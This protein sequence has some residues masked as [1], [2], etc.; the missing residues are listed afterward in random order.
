M[1][2]LRLTPH[3]YWPPKYVKKWDVGLDP[4]GGMQTQIYRM[5]LALSK[6]NVNQKILTIGMKGAQ[7]KIK[8]KDNVELCASNVPIIPIKSKVRGTVGLNFYWGLGVILTDLKILL[9]SAVLKKGKWDIIHSHCS[10][11]AA[12]LLVGII[13]K[14]LLKKPLVYTVHC[15]RLCTYEPM[16]KLDQMINKSIIKL[17]E[18]CLKKSDHILVLTQ[19]TKDLLLTNYKHLNDSKISIIPDIVSFNS[20]CMKVNE[21][22]KDFLYTKYKIPKDKRIISFVGRVAHEK[23]W[24]YLVQSIKLTKHQDYHVIFAGDGNERKE[25]EELIDK[26]NIKAIVTVTGFIPNELV[27]SVIDISEFLVVPSIHEELGSVLLEAASLKTTVIASAVGGIPQNIKDGFNGLLVPSKSPAA[28]AEKIDYLFDHRE[29]AKEMGS[30][31]YDSMKNQY[32]SAFVINKLMAR[33]KALL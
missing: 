11:V 6:K 19:K 10:G 24:S 31:L 5:T 26:L 20:F 14:W 28:I 1:N 32:D 33:Y 21:K 22:N 9:Q 15:C 18:Y 3:F 25:L 27:A 30:N 4:I 13:S 12:P 23:G 7:K 29:K 2:I 17:E 8:I 16:N